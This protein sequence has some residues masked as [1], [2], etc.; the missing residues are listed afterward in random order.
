[1]LTIFAEFSPVYYSGARC[2]ATLLN[3]MKRRGK[4]CRFGVISM[5]IGDFSFDLFPIQMPGKKII[6]NKQI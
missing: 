6:N 2:V 1:L 4:D 5:C 3:E